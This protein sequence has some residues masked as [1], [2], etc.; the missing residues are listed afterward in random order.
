MASSTLSSC[1]CTGYIHKFACIY[2]YISGFILVPLQGLGELRSNSITNMQ[3]MVFVVK[4]V[5][6]YT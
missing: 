1:N 3:Q 6:I 2:I 4:V 5:A